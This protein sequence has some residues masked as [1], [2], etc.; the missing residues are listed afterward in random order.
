MD[1]TVR[2]P[3]RRDPGKSREIQRIFKMLSKLST[4]SFEA[5][6]YQG[7]IVN[8]DAPLPKP[9]ALVALH[10]GAAAL[11]G[12]QVYTFLPCDS[13]MPKLSGERRLWHLP[14]LSIGAQET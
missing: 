9:E 10:L 6:G 14:A 12:F 11:I 8:H 3:Q 7:A 4:I 5:I 13:K 1:S 2:V